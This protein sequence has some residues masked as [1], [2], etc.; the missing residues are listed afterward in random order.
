MSLPQICHKKF[1]YPKTGSLLGNS[2]ESGTRLSYI[3][4]EA[5]DCVFLHF[6]GHVKVYVCCHV[7][8]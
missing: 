6:L 3:V 5:V 4:C 1:K 2:V 7:D 8:S